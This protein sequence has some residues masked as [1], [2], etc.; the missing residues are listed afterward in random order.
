VVPESKLLGTIVSILFT[1]QIYFCPLTNYIGDLKEQETFNSISTI[2]VFTE[3]RFLIEHCW[4]VVH[5]MSDLPRFCIAQSVLFVE[6]VV[7]TGLGARTDLVLVR[8]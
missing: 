7:D 4:C 8:E 5:K 2:L 1:R 6:V 3:C